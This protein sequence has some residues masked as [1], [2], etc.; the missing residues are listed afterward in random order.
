MLLDICWIGS[1]FTEILSYDE[2]VRYIYIC[3]Y[4]FLKL[5]FTRL[6]Y[7]LDP[8]LRTNKRKIGLTARREPGNHA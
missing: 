8:Y 3:I 6:V 2:S 4:I 5:E 1:K 7:D